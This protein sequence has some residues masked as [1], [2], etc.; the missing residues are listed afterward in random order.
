MMDASVLPPIQQEYVSKRR[1]E[2]L[3]RQRIS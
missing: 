1:M 3:E 2:I